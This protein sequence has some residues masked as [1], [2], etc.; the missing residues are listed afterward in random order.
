MLSGQ[1]AVSFV[2]CQP[3]EVVSEI[4]EVFPHDYSG[5]FWCIAGLVHAFGRSLYLKILVQRL[6]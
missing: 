2:A 5:L 3:S 1:L 6:L 4:L